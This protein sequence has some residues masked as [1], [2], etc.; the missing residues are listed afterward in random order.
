MNA[1]SAPRV[2]V[3]MAVYN[4]AAYLREAVE[5]VLAQT[6]GDF[7]F[8]I[9]DDGSTDE[10]ARIVQSYTDPRIRLVRNEGNIGLSASLNRGLE[11][12]HGTYVARMDADD[13]SLPKRLATQ[14]SFMDA[15]PQVG[16]CGSWVE[17]FDD[18][19]HTGTWGLP[20]DDEAL[21]CLLLFSPSLYHPTVMFRKRLFDD[22]ALRYATDFAQAQDYE[23][24][25]RLMDVCAFANIS[26]VLVRHRR[27]AQSV[28]SFAADGQLANATRVRKRMLQKFGF[29]PTEDELA[30]HTAL[31]LGKLP[32]DEKMFQKLQDWLLVLLD[33]NDNRAV[34]SQSAMRRLL[35]EKWYWLCLHSAPLGGYVWRGYYASPLRAFLPLSLRQHLMLVVGGRFRRKVV[36][37]N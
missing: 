11:L 33:R 7:E 12:A 3:L 31:A 2:T 14:I 26:E 35:A 20:T 21:K 27:H 22:A 10:S 28:G 37:T 25:C 9:V 34:F 18:S 8:V 32:S 4:G 15:H 29:E 16:I 19:Q 6:F 23:L 30:V 17:W 13:I 24:W 1:R 36:V 5:S